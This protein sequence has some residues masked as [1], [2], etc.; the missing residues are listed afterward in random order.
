MPFLIVRTEVRRCALDEMASAWTT[1]RRVRDERTS[2]EQRRQ[3]FSADTRDAALRLARA[4]ASAGPVRS[5]RQRI[6]VVRLGH[7]RPSTVD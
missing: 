3:T 2:P 6:K 7:E 4:L 1:G 5:G